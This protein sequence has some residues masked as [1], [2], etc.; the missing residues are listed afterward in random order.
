[1]TDA[2]TTMNDGECVSADKASIYLGNIYTVETSLELP[3]KGKAGSLIRWESGYPDVINPDGVVTRPANGKGN[4][5]VPLKAIITKGAATETRE[6][7]V[8]VL[9]KERIQPIAALKEA[10]VRTLTGVPPVLP[11]VVVTVREDGSFGVARVTWQAIAPRA[12]QQAGVFDVTGTV[13]ATELQARARITVAAEPDHGERSRPAPLVRPF[14]LHDVVLQDT[15]FCANHDRGLNFLRSVDDNQMLYNFRVAAGLDTL[16]AP[17]MTG[18]DAPDG[19]LRGHTTGHYLSA[20]ALAY[21]G[22]KDPVFA[23]KVAYMITELGRCQDAMEASGRFSPGF[24]SGYAE[25][26]FIRLEAFTVYPKIWAPYYTLHKIMAGLLDCHVLAGSRQA[27]DICARLGDWV[28]DRL[29]RLTSEHRNKMWAMYIAG[30]YGGM[31][32]TLAMLYTLTGNAKHLEAAKYFDNDNLFVPMAGGF[33]ALGGMHAN[34]HIPQIVGALRM[35]EADGDPYYHQVAA[36]FWNMVVQGHLYNIGGTGEG[37]MFR[38]VN[39]IGRY[40]SDKTAE[41]CATYNMLKL[42]RGLFMH[43]PDA[44]YM[45]YSERAMLNHMVATQDPR[46][47]RGGSTYFMPLGPGMSKGYDTDGNSCCHGTGLESH[48]RYQENIFFQAQDSSA[49]YVNLY[50]PSTLWWEEKYMHITL[51][52]DFLARQ[53]ITLTVDGNGPADIKLRVPSW[54][55]DGFAL[56][57]NGVGHAVDAQPGRYVTLSREWAAGDQ[58]E[59][60]IPFSLRLEPT[61][62]NPE[63]GGLFYGPL[64]MVARSDRS[65]YLELPRD[66]AALTGAVRLTDEP[67]TFV[68]GDDIPVTPNYAASEGPYHAYFKLV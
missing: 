55:R 13:E 65:T 49:L 50:I 24:L 40:I 28:H 59:I 27:L 37:E 8:T 67:L 6:F 44:R 47:P 23:S 19:N 63:I 12:L 26:Q 58:V 11:E 5:I 7:Q 51:A 14:A 54:A 22:T 18:W 56:K 43:D 31:N 62:D 15:L 35:Y 34:Q 36:H 66:S 21:A 16:G 30:E 39:R 68:M 52:G 42:S 41:S 46:G 38:P 1:M 53:G 48:V 20:I 61:P 32:E 57:I 60:S 2:A 3:K 29:G 45:D 9:E 4:I 17:P 33:D 25:E 64:V 10:R